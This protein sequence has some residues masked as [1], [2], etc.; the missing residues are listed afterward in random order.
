MSN[1]LIKKTEKQK[2][3]ELERSYVDSGQLDP[4]VKSSF[5]HLELCGYQTLRDRFDFGQEQL[6]T[7]WNGIES[8]NQMYSLG[9]QSYQ[10]IT[11]FARGKGV[12][13]DAWVRSIPREHKLFL[14]PI[15]SIV[16]DKYVRN[17]FIDSTFFC[18]YM[19]AVKVLGERFAMKSAEIARFGEE[20]KYF[21]DSYAKG[22][23]TDELVEEMLMDECGIE[24]K[25]HGVA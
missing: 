13:I 16:P 1:K 18:Y 21:I 17:K 14:C 11:T 12:D 22:Y 25:E 24:V 19:L 6:R 10:S 23:L 2:R 3:K 5:R 7:Y 20:I 15:H 9:L 8:I 4:F